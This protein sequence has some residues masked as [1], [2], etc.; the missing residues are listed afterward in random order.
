MN[1]YSDA[2]LLKLTVTSVNSLVFMW[3]E[4]AN[5]YKDTIYIPYIDMQRL[6]GLSF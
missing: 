1:D 5:V 4:R 6:K 3:F 2:G